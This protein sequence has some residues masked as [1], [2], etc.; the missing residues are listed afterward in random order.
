MHDRSMVPDVFAGVPTVLGESPW[1]DGEHLS[2]IDILGKALHVVDLESGS[3]RSYLTPGTPGFAIPSSSKDWVLGLGDG[4]YTFT[5]EGERWAR[6]WVAPHD[7][8]THRINDAKTD[9]NGRLWMGSMTYAEREPAAAL[10]RSDR[11]QVETVLDGIITSNG[12]GWSPDNRTFYFTDS[13]VRTIWAFDFDLD[14]G[15]ISN[16]KVFARDPNGYVPDGLAVDDDGCVWSCKWDGG[17]I[18]RYSPDGRVVEE[19]VTPV[20]RPT[21]CAFVGRERTTLAVTTASSDDPRH[22]ELDG[23][24]LLY[25]VGVS[26]ALLSPVAVEDHPSRRPEPKTPPD[27]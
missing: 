10:Y 21:S 6:S 14:H 13:L 15:D 12:L 27:M 4:C 3:A 2:F 25:D 22:S 7:P 18:V 9:A 16:R 11:G 1:W 19:V 17:R 26:G 8:V 23:T 5:P 20:A 24:V